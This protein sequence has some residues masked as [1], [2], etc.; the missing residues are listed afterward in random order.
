MNGPTLTTLL[1]LGLLLGIQLVPY[2]VQNPPVTTTPEWSN[3]EVEALAR[4]ACFDCH[5]NETRTPWYGRI[6][7]IAWVLRRHVTEGRAALNLSDLE[8]PGEEAHEAGEET[9]EAEMPPAYY[10]ALHPEARLSD[11]ER[12]ALARELDR[13]LEPYAAA[14]KHED[15][16]HEG[17]D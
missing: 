7:P 8:H 2:K 1:A 3:A 5:S 15:D 16:E 17:D 4:R 12:Q 13:V 9:L 6:A 10:L 11:A 14:S